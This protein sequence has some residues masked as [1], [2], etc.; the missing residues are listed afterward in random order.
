M[1]LLRSGVSAGPGMSAG[2]VKF[3]REPGAGSNSGASETPE[4]LDQ[5]GWD[6]HSEALNSKEKR[7]RGSF[8]TGLTLRS[9]DLSD[10]IPYWPGTTTSKGDRCAL[11]RRP[12]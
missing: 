3:R 12:G 7:L 6:L 5:R 1:R 2:L 11:I 8:P 9:K 10:A 4:R